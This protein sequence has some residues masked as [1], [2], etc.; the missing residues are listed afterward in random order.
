[1]KRP[2]PSPWS[3]ARAAAWLGAA[4]GLGCASPDGQTV[5]RPR[6]VDTRVDPCT[7]FASYVCGRG[8]QAEPRAFRHPAAGVIGVI[9]ILIGIA[10]IVKQRS[11]NQS[12]ASD[13]NEEAK[14]KER[15]LFGGPLN[16]GIRGV[17]L[18]LLGL[19]LLLYSLPM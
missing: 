2:R 4:I 17:L 1:M 13:D 3:L 15:V 10:L 12:G 5:W 6:A 9:I 18:I 19:G 16:N 8:G 11:Q 14:A 7:D